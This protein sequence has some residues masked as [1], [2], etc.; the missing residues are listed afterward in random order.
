MFLC[1]WTAD[2]KTKGSGLN[3]SKHY[4]TR[5]YKGE[6]NSMLSRFHFNAESK[7]VLKKQL[8]TL[9]VESSS[10]GGCGQ[11]RNTE[12]GECP[13]LKAATKQRLVKTEYCS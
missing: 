6:N 1:F 4:P 2:E 11:F 12:E 3:G 7:G 10:C 5:A 13:P 9:S 8:Q